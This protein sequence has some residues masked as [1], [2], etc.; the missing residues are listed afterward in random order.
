MQ[1]SSVLTAFPRAGALFLVVVFLAVIVVPAGWAQDASPTPSAPSSHMTAQ[2]AGSSSSQP[3]N[4]QE[5]S[6]PKSSFPNPLAP[7][8]ARHVPPPNPVSY[9]HLTLPTKA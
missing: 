7:Y 6:K 4:V 2:T 5:Y 9:T 1:R 8:T 3:F